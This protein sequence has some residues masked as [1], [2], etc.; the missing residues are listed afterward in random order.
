[1]VAVALEVEVEVAVEV[2]VGVHSDLVVKCRNGISKCMHAYSCR[3]LRCQL[4]AELIN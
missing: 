1:V 3:Q 4:C 2:E